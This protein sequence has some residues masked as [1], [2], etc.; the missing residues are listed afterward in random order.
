MTDDLTPKRVEDLVDESSFGTAGAKNL[1]DRTSS[2]VMRTI[3]QRVSAASHR[4]SGRKARRRRSYSQGAVHRTL[5]AIG[6]T[7]AGQRAVPITEAIR[8]DLS[9]ILEE[10]CDAAGVAWDA[11]GRADHSDAVVVSASPEI[12]KAA[13]VE[14]LPHLLATAVRTYNATRAI[15]R[16][17]ALRMALHAGE[18]FD[19]GEPSGPAS[20]VTLQLLSAP[21]VQQALDDRHGEL[22]L[23]A[24]GWFFDEVVRHSIPADEVAAY[25]PVRVTVNDTTTIGWISVPSDPYPPMAQVDE[26]N[27][28]PNREWLARWTRRS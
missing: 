27:A 4:E 21:A 19:D 11:C 28:V 13:F 2:T 10:A 8:A 26:S 9:R 20:D 24:S 6:I 7:E 23:I 14:L 25:R 18:V 12:P 1:R 5:M 3:A 22:V 15:E 17:I 16:K